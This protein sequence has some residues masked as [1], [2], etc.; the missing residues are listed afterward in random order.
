V[1]ATHRCRV[2][3]YWIIDPDERTLQ[4]YRWH[5]DG[6]IGVQS[7]AAGEAV[8]AEPFG[9]IEIAIDALFADEGGAADLE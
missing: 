8:C 6:Y 1:R 7:A 5:A 9:E 2:G 3:H 4:V